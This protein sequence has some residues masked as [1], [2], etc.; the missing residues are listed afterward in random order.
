MK[1]KFFSKGDIHLTVEQAQALYDYHVHKND[2]RKKRKFYN[3]DTAMWDV[4]RVI[5]YSFDGSHSDYYNLSI[6]LKIF[7]YFFV[8]FFYNINLYI[9]FCPIRLCWSSK[10]WEGD[11][12]LVWRHVP[13]RSAPPPTACQSKRDNFHN[14]W[15]LCFNGRQKSVRTNPI[16][17]IGFGMHESTV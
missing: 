14:P 1:F 12:T 13:Q 11:K 15:R 8:K 9:N 10:N 2:R 5:D 6:I 7:K 3:S 17:V 4:N 16:L